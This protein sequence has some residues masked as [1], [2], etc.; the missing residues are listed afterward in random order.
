MPFKEEDIS[1][2]P[3]LKLYHDII[4]EEEIKTITDMASKNVSKSYNYY[5]IYI[6]MYP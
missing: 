6:R 5:N 1:S 4:Y 2:S 3:Y